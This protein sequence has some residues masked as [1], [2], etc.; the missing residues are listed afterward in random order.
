MKDI[1]M[2]YY[3]NNETVVN[4]YQIII[5]RYTEVDFLACRDDLTLQ[6]TLPLSELT[7][8]K[9]LQGNATV[10]I[11]KSKQ[12]GEIDISTKNT[13]DIYVNL[14]KLLH[15]HN[16]VKTLSSSSDVTA[17]KT[18]DIVE[19]D[20]IFEKSDTTLEILNTSKSL[21]EI[22]ELN[23]TINNS[24][25]IKWIE[26]QTTDI[27][28]NKPI[29]FTTSKLY[30]S[31]FV[32]LISICCKN[33]LMDMECYLGREVTI[34]GEVTSHSS[35]NSTLTLSN[36]LGISAKLL[37]EMFNSNEKYSSINSKLNSYI[38][39]TPEN[40]N[41]KYIEIVPIIIYL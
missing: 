33:S 34:L 36:E 4:L 37:M 5:N 19:F 24:Q 10:T 7:C 25:I 15:K 39:L 1:F 11:L 22:Q 35:I 31:E 32:G 12:R 2:P 23:E 16:I 14:E 3:I 6:A 13:I 30:N 9:I 17:L 40:S 8:G 20:C 28:Q 26:A 27:I 41:Q 21:L 18:G 29:K 38:E